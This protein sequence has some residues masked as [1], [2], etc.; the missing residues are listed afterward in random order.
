M[1]RLG[2]SAAHDTYTTRTIGCLS[3]TKQ[4]RLMDPGTGGSCHHHP[5]RGALIVVWGSYR[6]RTKLIIDLLPSFALA[7]ALTDGC[8]TA[9]NHRFTVSS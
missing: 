8:S 6:L 9:S 5:P 3:R 7:L 1:G 4:P 2:H